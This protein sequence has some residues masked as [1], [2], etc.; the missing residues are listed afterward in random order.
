[1]IPS[2]GTLFVAREAVGFRAR[3]LSPRANE[4][5]YVVSGY[6]GQL[7]A[8]GESIV[9]SDD[10][11]R[12]IDSRSY[13]ADPTPGQDHLRVSEILYKPVPPS[14]EELASIPTLS[15][16]SFEFV[17]LTNTGSSPLDLGG[18]H[19]VAGIAFT[20][21]SPTV[22]A[23]GDHILVVADQ[24]AF[25]LRYGLGFN[26]AG[27]YTGKLDNDGEEVQILDAVGENIL[28]FE[29]NDAWYPPTGQQGYSLVVLDPA[30]IPVTGYDLPENWGISLAVGGDPGSAST[31][32]SMTFASWKYREFT[33]AEIA[34]PLV[35]G[36]EIDLDGDQLDT[37]LEYGLGQRPKIFDVPG[38]SSSVVN[39]GGTD[40]HAL[41]FRRRKNAL[42]LTYLVEMSGDL[43]NWTEVSSVVGAPVDNGDGTEMVTVRDNT[44]ASAHSRRFARL[45]VVVAP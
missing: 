30:N 2:R 27:Q 17:E 23:P 3:S 7:S 25:E 19:F 10:S 31:V 8:R 15:A 18:A 9:L 29:Y 33:A 22:L 6:A 41:T 32:T 40:Y 38:Y 42:D 21:P 44:P 16:S 28:E 36:P 45:G 11:G 37:V 4:K 43:A 12:Q 14:A 5:R 34:D 39:V 1:M 20:F 13:P 24:A 35:T 26:I